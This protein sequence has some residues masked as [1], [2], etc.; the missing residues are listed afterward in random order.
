MRLKVGDR[1]YTK[2][3]LIAS[4]VEVIVTTN[5][6]G[7]RI[8]YPDGSAITVGAHQVEL[9][10]ARCGTCGLNRDFGWH[11]LCDRVTS[12]ESENAQLRSYL[13]PN[14]VVHI[15]PEGEFVLSHSPLSTGVGCSLC[16][17]SQ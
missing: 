15:G 7:Y 14:T 16:K 13:H 9:A 1:V 5:G 10:E 8:Q 2:G 12:L 11:D 6:D 4:V 17:S 3:N